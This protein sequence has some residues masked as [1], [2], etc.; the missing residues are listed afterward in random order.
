MAPHRSLLRRLEGER[1][2]NCVM[3]LGNA[4]QWHL[5]VLVIFDRAAKEV[6]LEQF[7]VAKLAW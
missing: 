6:V 4:G 7:P 3:R 1:Q 5:R 2:L